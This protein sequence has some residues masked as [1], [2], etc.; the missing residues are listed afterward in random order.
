MHKPIYYTTKEVAKLLNVSEQRVRA[1]IKQG[2]FKNLKKKRIQ[3]GWLISEEDVKDRL[4]KKG[5]L[6]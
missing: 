3:H 4:N 1:M 5:A 2:H 6:K